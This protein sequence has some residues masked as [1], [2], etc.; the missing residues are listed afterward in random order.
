MQQFKYGGF[1]RRVLASL[2]DTVLLAIVISPLIGILLN[3]LDFSYG[4]VVAPSIFSMPSFSMSVAELVVNLLIPA[5]VVVLFWIYKSATPGKMMVGLKIIDAE[6]GGEPSKAQ[7]IGRYASYYISLL[8]AMLGFFWI[9]I[10]GRKQ[11]WHDKL[12]GTLVVKS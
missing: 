3:R 12:A 8:P 2:I 7:L 11:G 9:A 6:T 5:C 4:S 10:D 1:W